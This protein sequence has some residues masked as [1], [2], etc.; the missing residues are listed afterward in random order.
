MRIL[1]MNQPSFPFSSTLT[2][3]EAKGNG[4]F[5]IYKSGRE[6]EE[7]EKEKREKEKEEKKRKMSSFL[8]SNKFIG[9][10]C[11]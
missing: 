5:P 7:E 8:R 3:E 9:K 11:K 10:K 1:I 4:K 6:G 2:D